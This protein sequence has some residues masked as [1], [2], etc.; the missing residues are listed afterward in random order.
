M[1]STENYYL[2][3]KCPRSQGQA[4]KDWCRSQGISMNAAITLLMNRMVRKNYQLKQTLH[5]VKN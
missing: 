1:N 4:F 5:K 3:V 2:M